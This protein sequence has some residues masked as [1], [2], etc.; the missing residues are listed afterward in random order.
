[1]TAATAQRGSNGAGVL[2]GYA[3]EHRP[4]GT[5]AA[6]T[7]V[8]GAAFGGALVATARSD[9]GFPRRIGMGDIA[10]VGV[11]SY[12]LSRQISKD[13]VLSFVR[14]PFTRYQGPGAPGEVEEEPRGTGLQLA[15]GELLTCPYCLGQWVSSGFVAGLLLAPR[16]TRAVAAT[17]A[18]LA[19]SDGLQLAFVLAE[20]KRS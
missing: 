6:M 15:V 17:F 13:K 3:E 14:A 2:E 4:L 10:L 1:M 19:I 7:A 8:Y 20:G 9:R 11:A 12:K 5:Y 16:P 18:A